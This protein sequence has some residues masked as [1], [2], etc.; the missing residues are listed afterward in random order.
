[1]TGTKIDLDFS[2]TTREVNACKI[3]YGTFDPSALS[4]IGKGTGPSNRSINLYDNVN[5]T[6]SL[7][8]AGALNVT[9]KVNIDNN[10]EFNGSL[11]QWVIHTPEDT[12]KS[13]WIAPGKINLP[14]T[15]ED[16]N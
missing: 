10:L 5:V 7:T 1:L 8:T 15:A 16:W 13:M 14:I 6:C 2:D 12:R 3:E 11:N 4:I 9:G